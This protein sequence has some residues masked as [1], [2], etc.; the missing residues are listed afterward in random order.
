MRTYITILLGPHAYV[1]CMA[2]YL[3]DGG[4]FEFLLEAPNGL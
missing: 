2:Q 4:K 3:F 1:G